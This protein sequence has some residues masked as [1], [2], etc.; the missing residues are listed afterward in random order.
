MLIASYI[1]LIKIWAD[2]RRNLARIYF[3]YL[4]RRS[5]NET[6]RCFFERI[7]VFYG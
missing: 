2:L 7:V 1:S 3:L 6:I 5:E 4:C